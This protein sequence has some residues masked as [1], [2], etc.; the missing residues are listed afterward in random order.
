MVMEAVQTQVQVEPKAAELKPLRFSW[1]SNSIF[2]P[3]GYGQQSAIVVNRLAELG[4]QI[5][6]IAFFGLEGGVLQITPNITMFPKRYHPY[7]NDIAVPH[8]AAFN[9]QFMIS[10]MDTWVMNPEEYPREFKWISYFPVDHDPMPAIVR[11]KLNQ[12][13]RRIS[14]SKFGVEKT[15]EAGLDC[16]YIPHCYDSRILFPR[17]KAAARAAIGMPSDKWI[18]GTVAMNKGNPSRK[19]FVEM[20]TA[21]ANFHKRHPETFYFLQTDRGEGIPD[22]VNLPEL[23]RQLGL[24]EGVDY[25]FCNQYTNAIGFPVQYFADMYSALDVH[26]LAS[27]GEGFGIPTLESQACGTPVIVG[28]W[29]ASSELCYAGHKI[30]KKDA[31]PFYTALASYQFKPHIRAVELAL[32]AEYRQATPTRKAMEIIK[33]EYDADTVVR[34]RWVPFLADVAGAL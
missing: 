8:S 16:V 25:G 22:S 11:Q 18:V 13:W 5:G 30:D 15:N 10:L 1:L 21:F 3:S 19:N 6:I 32:E 20:M 31:E 14:M 17:D 4:H 12:A 28:D 27:A 9:A 7:G 26:M 29:T 2:A 33:A 24:V 23:A 34:D